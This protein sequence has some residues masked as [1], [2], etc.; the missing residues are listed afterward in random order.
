MNPCTEN[1]LCKVTAA[2]VRGKKGYSWRAGDV[3]KT[4]VDKF[5]ITKKLCSWGTKSGRNCF[6]VKKGKL[7]NTRYPWIFGQLKKNGD[8]HWSHG[9]VTRF[10]TPICKIF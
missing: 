6:K 3:S 8:I 4:P 5:K 2:K 7:V 9:F 1:S 10:S